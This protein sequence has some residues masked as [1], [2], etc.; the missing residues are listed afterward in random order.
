MTSSISSASRGGASP[1]VDRSV[2]S[3]TLSVPD[4]S[5][6]S[7]MEAV[8][9]RNLPAERGRES[10][11]HATVMTGPPAAGRQLNRMNNSHRASEKT[12]TSQR[13]LGFTLIELL[14]V[15]AI[16]A[17]LAALLLPALSQAK[18][19]AQGIYCMNNQKQMAL[20]WIMYADDNAGK[21]PPNVDGNPP[22]PTSGTL[23]SC[24]SWVAGC[25]TLYPTFSLDN[26]N[27]GMLIDHDTHPYA[28]YL[29]S[30]IKTSAAFKCPADLST[31]RIYGQTMDRV[32]SVSMN[33]FI[34]APS[35][36]TSDGSA[37]PFTKPQGDSKYP[38]YQTMS[39]I[40]YPSTTFVFLDEREDSINDGT[41][42]TRVDQPGYLEDVPASYHGGSSGFSFA[43]GHSEM[44]KWTAGYITQPIQSSK[45]NEHNM[46]GDPGVGDVYWLDLNAVG[47]GSF[48]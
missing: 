10:N 24:P 7:D 26:T 45:I 37:D 14:V 40:R 38:P 46:V 22:G 18:K 35:H 2:Y 25:L 1:L 39:S 5:V 42:F 13:R 28:A 21:P 43:D 15:I 34:G 41:F 36:S 12:P 4:K 47:T 33:N 29:G 9:G 6:K 20:A 31:A 17:I 11:Q 48:P 30:Y 32:R 23:A 27:T 8:V 16:I 3:K 44:H 19:R